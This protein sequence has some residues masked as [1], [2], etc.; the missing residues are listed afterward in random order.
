[1]HWRQCC[2]GQR[3]DL[4][5]KALPG[6]P[7]ASM[8]RASV[9]TATGRPSRRHPRPCCSDA[10]GSRA[11]WQA[12]AK[13]GCQQPRRNL[14]AHTDGSAAPAGVGGRPAT[15]AVHVKSPSASK[16]S[17]NANA[18]YHSPAFLQGSTQRCSHQRE[19]LERPGAG[20]HKTFLSAGS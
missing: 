3:R 5:R 9:P 14:L 4:Q 15:L 2:N 10:Q 16:R 6:H 1:M 18:N 8:C 12:H 11:A 20:T 13:P 17:Q 19:A 7:P